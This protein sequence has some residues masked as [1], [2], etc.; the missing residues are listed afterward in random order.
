MPDPA[1]DRLGDRQFR[2]WRTQL[3]RAMRQLSEDQHAVGE[4][5]A[6]CQHEAFGEAVRSRAT[7]RDLEHLDTGIG[8]HRVK[9][10]RELPL[11][12]ADEKPEPAD[13]IAEI[14]HQTVERAASSR[15][16]RA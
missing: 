12:I 11:A 16:H 1:V 3:Q 15:A 7:R 2:P 8:Q 5:G 4:F 14:R 9:R 10:A 13:V 6:D